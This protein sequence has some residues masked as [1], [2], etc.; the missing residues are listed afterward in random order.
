MPGCQTEVNGSHLKQAGTGL[1]FACRSN[2]RTIN[3]DRIR[4]TSKFHLRINRNVRA[5]SNIQ[6]NIYANRFE[7][8][9]GNEKVKKEKKKKKKMDE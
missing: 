7:W 1:F 3:S 9:G 5:N 2:D 6:R 8:L 4:H